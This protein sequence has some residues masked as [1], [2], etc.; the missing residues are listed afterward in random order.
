MSYAEAGVVRGGPISQIV[1]QSKS[2]L[3]TWLFCRKHGIPCDE[4]YGVYVAGS[5]DLLA[6]I[7]PMPGAKERA[8][9]VANALN[10]EQEGGA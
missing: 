3:R 10:A 4:W 2:I 9:R 1:K 7:G 5:E 6:T 8:V